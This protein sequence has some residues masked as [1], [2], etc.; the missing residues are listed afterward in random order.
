MKISR[1][2]DHKRRLDRGR[3][4][5]GYIQVLATTAILVKVFKINSWWVY[6]LGAMLVFGICYI[7]GYMDDKK[8]VLANEQDSYNK[9]N[10]FVQTVLNDLKY[11]KSKL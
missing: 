7:L 1:I 6:V 2:A 3:V 5:F 11:I 10:P 8:K 9:E 4:Y